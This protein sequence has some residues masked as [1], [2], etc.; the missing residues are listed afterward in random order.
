[1]L[2]S[3]LLFGM[4]VTIAICVVVLIV[5]MALRSA[6]RKSSNQGIRIS[7]PAM[8]DLTDHCWSPDGTLI[9]CL[10]ANEVIQ[11]WDAD[12]KTLLSTTPALGSVSQMRWAPS[13]KRL[14]LI[15]N[16]RTIKLLDPL[17]GLI[18]HTLGSGSALDLDE[19]FSVA[20]APDS[21]LL[22]TGAE[23]NRIRFW[24]P[25]SGRALSAIDTPGTNPQNLIW[26]NDGSEVAASFA[27]GSIG[28]WEVKTRRIKWEMNAHIGR[29]QS[30]SWSS[31]GMLLAS[32]GTDG[33]IRLWD[34][35][36]KI[37]IHTLRP[38]SNS[39]LKILWSR[40]DRMLISASPNGIIQVWDPRTGYETHRL[41][42]VI[43][44][45]LDLT[46]SPDDKLLAVFGKTVSDNIVVWE[47][48][49]WSILTIQSVPTLFP[50]RV[51][52]DG[53]LLSF[54]PR[55][56]VLAVTA[57]LTSTETA[58]KIRRD[59]GLALWDLDNENLLRRK[60]PKSTTHY[61]NAKVLLLGDTGVGKSG[62]ALVLCDKPF[63][64]TYSTHSRN[65]WLMYTET[66]LLN[67]YQKEE[68][69]VLLWD[70][71][72]QP[73]YRVT[74]QLHLDETSVAM[75]V[76]D[77]RSETDPFAGVQYWDRALRQAY[78]LQ[79]AVAL[80]LRKILVAARSDR[81]GVGVSRERIDALVSGMGFD[82]YFE[83]SSRTGR[84]ISQLKDRILSLIN[85]NT[86][87]KVSSTALFQSMKTFLL[88]ETARGRVLSTNNDLFQ[89]LSAS[90]KDTRME[91]ETITLRAQFETAIGLLEASNL[92]KRL[93]FGH[94]IL[95]KPEVLD[96]YAS[97]LVNAVRD[98]PDGLGSIKESE[99]R[100][101]NFFI[102]DEQRLADASQERLLVL[103]MLEDLLRRELVLRE[104][105]SAGPYLVFPSQSSRVNPDL[106]D[107]LGKSVV[108]EFEGSILNI[109][110]TL[111]VRLS[112]SGQFERKDLW[113]NA[114]TYSAS[115]SGG[116]CGI[117]LQ[118]L[119]EG[120]GE[121]T[122]F[123]EDTVPRDTRFYFEAYIATHLRRLAVPD[124]VKMTPIVSCSICGTIF[125]SKQID[126]RKK[127]G[128]AK[129]TCPIC[130]H[131]VI[132]D[133]SDA[134]ERM[135]IRVAASIN[136]M[137]VAADRKRD[138][139]AAATVIVG[140]Q[141]SQQFDVFLSYHG[142]DRPHVEAIADQLL[143][144][145]IRPWLDVW[146][147]APGQPWM[148]SIEQQIKT[149]PSAAVFFGASGKAPWRDLE[150]QALLRQFVKRGCPVI[151]VILRGHEGDPPE[152][153]IFLEGMQWVDF[154][155]LRPSPLERLLWGIT[156]A[157][158]E[159]T[160][161]AQ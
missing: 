113:Q 54:H 144:R 2:P 82:G 70:L 65:V 72:G 11:V 94:L 90:Y 134:R 3:L 88:E 53:T 50:L 33:L 110:A 106:P 127:L 98:E 118:N 9:A 30:L 148:P 154:R 7:L 153:P 157:L 79:G 101:C 104:E 55:K 99:V 161:K 102:P 130:G 49:T 107:P 121:L 31:R 77:G 44:P 51:Q 12:R 117:A 100:T 119:G 151:P 112:H 15:I 142:D 21:Q 29:I 45:V 124:S 152:L 71:A 67:P 8:S 5:A 132:I 6:R 128:E 137:D 116:Q 109:Y 23:R 103:A 158:S 18:V 159:V 37:Q 66:I 155:R 122:V 52:I 25:G 48:D 83:T 13:S 129:L 143:E 108:F 69:E 89:Q 14:A 46:L 34:T 22:A 60:S 145:G 39:I 105:T 75:I 125:T 19:V 17:T 138:L 87:P 38:L 4:L 92:I 1:M 73:G 57:A 111:A 43:G 115:Q 59:F 36:R 26:S 141:E 156:S 147:L 123:F 133:D 85:W 47:T 20:W 16:Y 64:S 32:V 10:D 68:H 58:T 56:S 149:I 61:T 126:D 63:E 93:S 42:G 136:A 40:D 97:A 24:D 140:K 135:D 86:V 78:S 28:I 131:T 114:I 74:H 35:Y 139:H 41:E 84:N 160:D 146:E 76:F 150:M 62:L 91:Q 81:G 80:P 95:M 27:D 96:F 120:R